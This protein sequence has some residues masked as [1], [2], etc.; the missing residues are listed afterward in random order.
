MKTTNSTDAIVKKA[1]AHAFAEIDR[2]QAQKKR[3]QKSGALTAKIG[4]TKITFAQQVVKDAAAGMTVKTLPTPTGT[5][6]AEKG[7]GVLGYLRAMRT[8]Q[9]EQ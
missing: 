2:R 7:G 5:Q 1:V 4:G 3:V 9:R 8:L 6:I